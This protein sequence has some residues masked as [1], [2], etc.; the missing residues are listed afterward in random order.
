MG[1]NDDEQLEIARL[2]AL[3]RELYYADA[4]FE[5]Q[6]RRYR[7]QLERSGTDRA[8]A[9]DSKRINRNRK[10]IAVDRT[11]IAARLAAL[12]S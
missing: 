12:K 9:A 6:Q 4:E 3:D 1:P 10:R 2:E 8:F 5:H 7:D 11:E